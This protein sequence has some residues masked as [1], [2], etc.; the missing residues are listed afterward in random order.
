[1]KEQ[2]KDRP[3]ES[4][5]ADTPIP[6]TFASLG[7]NENLLRAITETGYETPSPIQAA[8]IPVLIKGRDVVGQAQ[9]G[10]G[11]TAAFA[12][13]ALQQLDLELQQPQILVLT[14]TRELAIQVAEAMQTYARYMKGFHVLPVYGGA[15]MDSQLRQLRRGVQ[16][17]VGTPGR[18]QDHIR[19][20]TLNL[21]QIKTVVLDE[22]DEMLR[23]GFVDDVDAILSHTPDKKQVALFSATMPRAIRKIA[24]K[25]LNDPVEIDIKSKSATVSTVRQRYCQVNVRHKMDALTRILEVESFDAMLV[26]VR[27]RTAT[28]E[29][30]EKLEARGFSSAA[31][32]GDM[33]QALRERMVTRLK[34]GGLDILVA[35]DVAARGLHVERISHVVNY[36][37][38]HDTEA[39]IHRVGRTARAGRSGEAIIFVAPRENRMLHAI[40]RATGQTIEAMPLP[41]KED[42]VDRRITQF[43]ELISTTIESEDLGAFES[44]IASYQLSNEVNLSEIAA[45]LAFL[46]QRDRP[47]SPNL[48]SIPAQQ[49][50][51][52]KGRDKRP[53]RNEEHGSNDRSA[54]TPREERPGEH[55][56]SERRPERDRAEKIRQPDAGMQRYR[57]AVG[58]DHEAL[59]KNI[60]GAIANEAGLDST[61]IG[62]IKLYDSYSTVDLPEDMPKDVFKHLQGVYVCGQ[63]LRI[64]LDSDGAPAPAKRKDDDPASAAKPPK[65]RKDKTKKP[66]KPKRKKTEE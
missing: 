8:A 20:G 52:D 63:K 29:L 46:V 17:V 6:A 51:R 64:S 58:R 4:P 23:M 50:S 13:P 45:A 42:I 24:E 38:P 60:V 25:H 53:R 33:T 48:P 61:N 54:R 40:E 21:K 35:T 30:A 12:L 31:L 66:K 39:Y 44:I 11:K 47:L 1:M 27:T 9:T 34:N 37:I 41:S 5:E 22:A 19:R 36:D 57:I 28:V 62:Y 49:D 26:F 65:K 18:I 56:R 7:L 15:G 43:K 16:A 55:E 10:T 32:N 14:P 59:P 3:S 2:S